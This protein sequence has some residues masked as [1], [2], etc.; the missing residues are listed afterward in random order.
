MEQGEQAMKH[1]ASGSL[2]MQNQVLK[3]EGAQGG[4][5]QGDRTCGAGAC[6]A[7][8][9]GADACGADERAGS[10]QVAGRKNESWQRE[11]A[12]GEGVGK[13]SMEGKGL[14]G[15]G[16]W[17]QGKR[18]QPAQEEIVPLKVAVN[19]A[20]LRVGESHQRAK[21]TDAEV[22]MIRRL[23]TEGL[24]YSE[25]AAK[26]EVNRFHVG[27]ICRFERRASFAVRVKGV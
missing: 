21:L 8:A 20:G 14:Q 6:G 23:H 13:V 11:G 4:K 17:G 22:E 27:K 18:N 2:V 15:D 12:R 1:V 24:T 9:C 3:H 26:F 7:D 25:L 10:A 5:V 16:V 19:E